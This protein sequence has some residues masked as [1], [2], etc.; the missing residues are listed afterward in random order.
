MTT[1]KRGKSATLACDVIVLNHLLESGHTEIASEFK[2]LRKISPKVAN[3]YKHLNLRK[4]DI[5]IRQKSSVASLCRKKKSVETGDKKEFDKQDLDRNS[6]RF[7]PEELDECR[8]KTFANINIK[9]VV[10]EEKK[11][12]L[13]KARNEVCDSLVVDYL[14]RNGF[15]DVLDELT[16]QINVRPS[17]T[18]AEN[19]TLEEIYEVN[20]SYKPDGDVRIDSW[21]RI[22][23]GY[24]GVNFIDNFMAVSQFDQIWKC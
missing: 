12:H 3:A 9:Q 18:F 14:K 21:T 6:N 8:N 10:V 4:M 24:S 11:F 1:S 23:E 5:L 22:M 19:F 20:D 2:T 13:T 16:S 15:A 17:S 7:E